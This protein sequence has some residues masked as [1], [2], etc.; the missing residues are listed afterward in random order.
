[1]TLGGIAGAVPGQWA[2]RRLAGK[3]RLLNTG[4]AALVIATGTYILA[5]SAARYW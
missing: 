1:M 5:E 3:K 4:F 2:S